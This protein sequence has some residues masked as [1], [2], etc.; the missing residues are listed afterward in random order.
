VINT[1]VTFAIEQQLPWMPRTRSGAVMRPDSFC[2][3]WRYTNRSLT[4]VCLLKLSYF[5]TCL[6]P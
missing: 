3:F 1:S 4:Y 6:L 2:W 5:L